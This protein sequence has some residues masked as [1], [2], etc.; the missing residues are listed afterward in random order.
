MYESQE[1]AYNY[2]ASSVVSKKLYTYLFNLML[3]LK[4]IYKDV[5]GTKT[6]NKELFTK[7]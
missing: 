2:V 5:F 3:Y 4:S 7:K 1:F 6:S